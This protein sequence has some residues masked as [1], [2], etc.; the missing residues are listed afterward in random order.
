M[1]VCVCHL[2]RDQFDIARGQSH[3]GVRHHLSLNGAQSSCCTGLNE[4][5]QHHI[6]QV[7]DLEQTEDG[8]RPSEL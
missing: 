4:A 3:S 1:C 6:Q 2:A 8:Q 7:C 5:V